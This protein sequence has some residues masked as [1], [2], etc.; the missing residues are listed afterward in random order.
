[1]H[2]CVKYVYTL[3]IACLQNCTAGAT[4]LYNLCE[5]HNN[6]VR[7]LLPVQVA[8]GTFHQHSYSHQHLPLHSHGLHPAYVASYTPAPYAAGATF[9]ATAMQGLAGGQLYHT[10]PPHLRQLASNVPPTAVQVYPASCQV[11]THTLPTTATGAVAH[12]HPLHTVDTSVTPATNTVN[13]GQSLM[14]SRVEVTG[15]T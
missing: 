3:F 6:S 4:G 1:M 2:V 5:C 10:S 13:S 12:I 9:Q 11:T 8:T 14:H 15:Y 7:T